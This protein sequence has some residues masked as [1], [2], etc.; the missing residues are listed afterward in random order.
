[1]RNS[2]VVTH[3]MNGQP[4][5]AEN[6]RTDG[7]DLWSYDTLI[8]TRPNLLSLLIFDYTAP[9]GHCQS[10]TTSCHVNMAKRLTNASV[11]IPPEE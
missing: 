6:L 8:G 5:A 3:W 11:T 4:G 9:A 1:M 10:H 7:V 2:E